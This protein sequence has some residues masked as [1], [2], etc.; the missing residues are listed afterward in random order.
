MGTEAFWVPVA[1][2]ALS[3]GGEYANQSNAQHRQ[4]DATLKGL[5][6][7]EELQS[8]AT[9]KASA[10]T[11]QIAQSTPQKAQ[12]QLTGDYV[13]QL[14]R[15][16]AG[17]KGDPT[18]KGKTTFGASTSALAP[19]AGGSS[20]YNADTG[21]SQQEVANYG[22]TYAS[23]AAAIDAAVAQRRGESAGM[24]DLGTQ[25]NT[26]GAQSQATSFIDQLRAKV[27]GQANPWLTLGSG[28]LSAGATGY[29]G[30]GAGKYGK[31]GKI[32][33]SGAGIAADSGLTG[34]TGIYA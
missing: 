2:T 6:D 31:F 28:M 16:A 11:R 13:N 17:S 4:D 15:N 9:S 26:L 29:S 5:H 24:Q 8:A 21:A 32:P 1:L 18:T 3:A 34:A 22:D 12:G 7:Q 14:R 27:A 20:R 30:S 25:L 23:D 10:L 19:V 33:K